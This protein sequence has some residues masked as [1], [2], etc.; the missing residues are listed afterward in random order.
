VQ[1]EVERIFELSRSMQLIVLDADTINHPAQLQKTSLAPI[2]VCL[3][4][5]NPKVGRCLLFWSARDVDV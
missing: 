3:K 2:M 1:R 4:I 5:T